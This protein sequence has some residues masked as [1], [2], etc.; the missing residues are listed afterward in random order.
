[1]VSR[2]AGFRNT[3]DVALPASSDSKSTLN[4]A[5][6]LSQLLI[7]LHALLDL[8]SLHKGSNACDIV[9]D[10]TVLCLQTASDAEKGK[11]T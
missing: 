2:L 4:M 11:V 8:Q 1:M 5:S 3:F 6:N 9:S 7:D 10:I